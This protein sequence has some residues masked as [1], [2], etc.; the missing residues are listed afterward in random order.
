[1]ETYNSD[2]QL[3]LL[4]QWLRENGVALLAGLV[5]GALIVAGW[6]AW[7]V[8]ADRQSRQASG[9]FEHLREELQAG[10]S[11]HAAEI[12]KRLTV[13][14]A[15][16]PYA[17]LGALLVAADQVKRNQYEPALGSYQW[18]IEEADDRKLRHIARLRQARLLWSLGRADEA[19]EV[20]NTRRAGSFSPMFAELR[21]DIYAGQGRREEARKAY[22]EALEGDAAPEQR[23]AVELKL[24][25]LEAPTPATQP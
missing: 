17:A 22:A 23:A 13:D 12:G 25:D 19:L 4:R 1:M 6:T 7:K 9:E 24:N 3:H 18:V 11:S 20:L 2:E 21:G 14:Y 8:Y 10:N 15:G 16:T 5:L